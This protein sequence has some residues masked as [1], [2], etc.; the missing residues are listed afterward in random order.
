MAVKTQP[1]V[2]AARVP[3]QSTKSTFLTAVEPVRFLRLGSTTDKHIAPQSEHDDPQRVRDME[4]Q[5]T[6]SHQ[7]PRISIDLYMLP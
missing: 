4:F 1:R 3:S 2:G 7:I 6:V 5:L